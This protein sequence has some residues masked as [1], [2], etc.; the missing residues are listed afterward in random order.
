MAKKK[1]SVEFVYQEIGTR[2]TRIRE[3]AG[4][5][6]RMQEKFAKDHKFTKG[7][8][9]H[10]EKGKSIP[11]QQAKRLI[12]ATKETI[13]GLTLDWIYLGEPRGVPLETARRLRKRPP[14]AGE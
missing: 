12:E 11:W 4:Y 5:P 8:W 13:P 14:S 6:G 9:N 10:W 3:L 7:S 1:K 2:L